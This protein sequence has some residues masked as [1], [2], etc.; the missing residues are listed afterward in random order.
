M[1]LP[2]FG[3]TIAST[4]ECPRGSGTRLSGALLEALAF[5]DHFPFQAL[6]NS[7]ADSRDASDAHQGSE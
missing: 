5:I 4:A 3:G 2:E 1:G 7:V 6:S